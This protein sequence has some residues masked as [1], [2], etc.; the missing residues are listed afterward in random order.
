MLTEMMEIAQLLR[1]I[2]AVYRR[3]RQELQVPQEVQEAYDTA[4]QSLVNARKQFR[5]KV[6]EVYG[7]TATNTYR[8]ED[9]KELI[10]HLR[11]YKAW[12]IFLRMQVEDLKGMLYKELTDMLHGEAPGNGLLYRAEYLQDQIGSDNEAETLPN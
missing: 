4:V 2:D 7:T 6:H 8:A 11:A 1:D 5:L 10:S 9:P 3:P 12:I